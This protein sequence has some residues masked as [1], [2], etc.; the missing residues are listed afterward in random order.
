MNC[1]LQLHRR[2][3][4][5]LSLRREQFHGRRIL[6][7]RFIW[8]CIATNFFA[9]KPTDAL[10]SKFI[11][12]QN[13][14]RFGQ[15]IC[16]SSGVFHCRVGTGTCYT[17]WTT[18]CMQDQ[19]GTAIPSWSCTQ[20]VVI[21]VQHMPVPN[22]QWKTPDDGQRNCAKR[23]EFRT[24]IN[25]EISASVGFIV[26]KSCICRDIAWYLRCAGHR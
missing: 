8:R 9:I 4:C 2:R 15:F 23:V 17:G 26:K 19:D 24:R 11:L 25:L 21:L 7:L 22:L 6:H 18:T 14:T 5:L 16:P 13:S 10:I 3:I 12:V 20:A 1:E